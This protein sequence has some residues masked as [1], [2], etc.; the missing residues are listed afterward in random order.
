M[1]AF[2]QAQDD[3]MDNQ[4]AGQHNIPQE[5]VQLVK[6]LLKD[7]RYWKMCKLAMEVGILDTGVHHIIHDIIRVQKMV[8][9]WVPHHLTSAYC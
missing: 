7:D 2:C 9:R 3:T 5:L 1:E 4:C 8:P 6:S